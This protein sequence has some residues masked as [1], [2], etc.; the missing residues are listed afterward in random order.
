MRGTDNV[1]GLLIVAVEDLKREE[2]LAK[3][4]GGVDHPKVIHHSLE[5]VFL[6]REFHGRGMRQVIVESQETS[7][8]TGSGRLHAAICRATW[9]RTRVR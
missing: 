9:G 6:A 2:V 4:V 7:T 5:R 3:S 8:S 1:A